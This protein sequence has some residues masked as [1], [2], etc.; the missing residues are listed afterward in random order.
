MHRRKRA[1]WEREREREEKRREP[2]P[3]AKRGKTC[4]PREDLLVREGVSG[5]ACAGALFLGRRR[6]QP[7]RPTQHRAVVLGVIALREKVSVS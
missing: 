6:R 2:G 4:F 5:A 1:S 7:E 3:K